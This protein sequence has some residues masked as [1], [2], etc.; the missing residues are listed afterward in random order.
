MLA[1]INSKPSIDSP[2]PA[3]D[4]A[5]KTSREV[6]ALPS[7]RLADAVYSSNSGRPNAS[8]RSR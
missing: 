1:A 3:S 5:D 2:A 7:F 4:N 6:T 8:I